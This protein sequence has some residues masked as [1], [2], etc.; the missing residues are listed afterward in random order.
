MIVTR[1]L[2]GSMGQDAQLPDQ[3][4]LEF[5][6]RVYRVEK[7]VGGSSRTRIDYRVQI[8]NLQAFLN[9]RLKSEQQQPRPVRLSDMSDNLLAEALSWQLSRGRSAATANK[10]R[11]SL[12]A[13]WRHA[14]EEKGFP[15]RP[16]RVK[17]VKEPKRKPQAWTIEDVNKI[18][19]AATRVRGKV[20]TVPAHRWFPAVL[21][22]IFNTGLRISAFMLCPTRGLNLE[23]GSLLVPAE[24]QKHDADEIYDLLPI[25]VEALAAIDPHRNRLLG[26]DWPHDRQQNHWRALTRAYRK[27]LVSAGLFDSCDDV[28]SRDLFHKL[29][30]TFASYVAKSTGTSGAQD[31]LGHSTPAVTQRYLDREIVGGPRLRDILP[32]PEIK[33]PL[34]VRRFE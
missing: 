10:L 24:V 23:R 7:L 11:R 33:L 28:T 1:N 16:L 32:T 20:G 4:L 15:G 14:V 9:E 5:F 8:S 12:V 29:R 21:L 26:D 22:T 25:T 34:R 13:V 6:D 3:P 27:I 30:R 31:A 19:E 2:F 17:P 18:V